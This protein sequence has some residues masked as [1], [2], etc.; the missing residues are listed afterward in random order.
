MTVLDLDS[1]SYFFG[2]INV[3]SEMLMWQTT[4]T[5]ADII[6]YT[7]RHTCTHAYITVNTQAHTYTVTYSHTY[8]HT[9]THTRTHIHIF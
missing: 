6:L 3:F 5:R 4:I 9:H 1:I 8:T 2:C 7:H